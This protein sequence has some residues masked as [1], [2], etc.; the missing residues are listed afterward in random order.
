V[1]LLISNEQQETAVGEEIC[2]LIEDALRDVLAG[3]PDGPVSRVIRDREAEVSLVLV[4]DVR[5]ESLNRQYRDIAGT[6]DVLSFSMLDE[7]GKEG[8]LFPPER[9]V[10]PVPEAEVLLGDIVISVP[11]ALSQ[12]AS[13]GNSFKTEMIFLAVHGMLH[14]LGY[15]DETESGAARMMERTRQ[16]MD[17]LGLGAGRDA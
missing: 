7:D 10:A 12:S 2:S 17:R 4:D 8:A 6:T 5:M 1:Q 15:D 11:R 3:E 9:V 13:F 16:V 14:L